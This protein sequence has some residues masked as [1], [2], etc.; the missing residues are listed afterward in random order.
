MYRR[1]PAARHAERVAADL[2]AGAQLQ[3]REPAAAKRFHDER[4]RADLD[5][6][7]AQPFREVGR[8]LR[9]AVE[10]ERDRRSRGHEVEGREVGGI[11]VGREHDVAPRRD[12]EA[13]HILAHG[14]CEHHARQV[15]LL[16][17]ERLL[18]R[19]GREQRLFRVDAPV[20]LPHRPRIVAEVEA[21]NEPGMPVIVEAEG[22]RLRQQ[23]EVARRGELAEDA[24]EPDGDGRVVDERVGGEKAATA[25]EVLLR[26]DH[27]EA[28]ARGDLS[29]EQARRPAADDEQVAMRI[30]GVVARGV[31]LPRRYRNAGCAPNPLLVEIPGRPLKGLVVKPGVP[32]RRRPV[33][34]AAQIEADARPGI[35]RAHFEPFAN[36]DHRRARRGLEFRAAAERDERIRL[37]GADREHAARPVELHSAA[38]DR[39]VVGE[40]RG[41]DGVAGERRQPAAVPAEVDGLRAVDVAALVEA[42]SHQCATPDAAPSSTS[43]P[44]A[45]RSR[46]KDSISACGFPFAIVQAIVSPPA[47]IAL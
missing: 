19:A 44:A 45:K 27:G 36:R 23:R 35:L 8:R 43:A 31:A 24:R 11:V 18:D 1:H 38:D 26:E 6:L 39:D 21:L 29:R 22:G 12:R 32:E 13:V 47:G 28:G 4:L 25:L 42:K 46:P 14:A 30:D 33:D 9:A 2:L 17:Q 16:E 37:L 40:Q 3:A 34:H 5:P 20:A 15:V 7:C 10:Q 41:S